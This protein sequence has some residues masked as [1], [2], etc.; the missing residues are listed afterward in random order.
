LNTMHKLN[1]GFR[2]WATDPDGPYTLLVPKGK[3]PGFIQRLN[4]LPKNQRVTW[5]EHTVKPGDTLGAIALK[6]NTNIHILKQVNHLKSSIIRPKQRL[7]I[8]VSF[9]GSI[10][11][12]IIKSH[13]TI[14]E[15]NL[16][17]PNRA[18]HVVEKGDTLWTVAE[19]YGV[20]TRELCFWNSISPK[21]GLI[22]GKKLLI[23]TPSHRH[24]YYGHTYIYKVMPGDSISVIAERFN[25]TSRKISHA[26]HLKNNA[27]RAG[28]ILHIPSGSVHYFVHTVKPGESLKIIAHKFHVTTAKLEKWNHLKKVKYIHPGDKIY[29]Y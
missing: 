25:S 24:H 11:S 19:K 3:A 22:A 26:N 17:G 13:A 27:I 16:P 7:L 10:S 28:Q 14:A 5:Q 18:I 8:P 9:H 1:P 20:T 4:A 29:I 23:W 2:R 12:P 15:E 21:K 6:Y